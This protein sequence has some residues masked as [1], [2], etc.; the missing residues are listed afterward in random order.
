M[1]TLISGSATVQNRLP[2]PKPMSGTSTPV[3]P[4]G[5]VGRPL[6]SKAHFV[7]GTGDTAGNGPE[8][9]GRGRARL[10]EVSPLHGSFSFA[11]ER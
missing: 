9:D 8:G 3:F 2:A 1:A 7:V 10:E 11:L 4:S 6:G 5:L